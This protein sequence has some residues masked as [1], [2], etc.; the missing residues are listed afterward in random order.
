MDEVFG[1]KIKQAREA[2]VV[3]QEPHVKVK[4]KLTE[5]HKAELL[6]SLQPVFA[7]LNK[8]LMLEEDYKVYR[9][10]K[11]LAKEL[12]EEYTIKVKVNGPNDI[13]SGL[14]IYIPVERNQELWTW[15]TDGNGET[16]ITLTMYGFMKAKAENKIVL[17]LKNGETIEKEFKITSK[18]TEV[19]FDLEKNVE[20]YISPATVKPG[21][22][23]TITARV[24]PPGV[25]N[26][27][28]TVT[29][30]KSQISKTFEKKTDNDGILV[31]RL[32]ITETNLEDKLGKNIVKVE[33]L[34]L[35]IYGTASFNVEESVEYWSGTWSGKFC[36][37]LE[38]EE[39]DCWE[40]S[41]KWEAIVSG[42]EATI[43]IY[44]EEG[45]LLGTGSG[46]WGRDIGDSISFSVSI[47]LM[48]NPVQITGTRASTNTVE[49][50]W[51]VRDPDGSYASGIWYGTI[52]TSNNP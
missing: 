29:N 52:K 3:M 48:E 4:N 10:L 28:I 17:V 50:T 40:E 7:K 42:T 44:D 27:K 45:T 36:W 16:Y 15:E 11:E 13:V 41:G 6:H 20:V 25:Y 9:M 39:E 49:G 5:K 19:T 1:E 22:K 46:I 12:S 34:D 18:T 2:W 47:D 14:K 23:V 37:V 35:G 21:E 30:V 32:E 26:A 24:S 38:N 8:D 33:I 31:F 51:N 43:K